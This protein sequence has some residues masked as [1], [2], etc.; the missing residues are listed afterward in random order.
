[1][2]GIGFQ[3]TG[4]HAIEFAAAPA[5]GFE[6]RI[7]N[8]ISPQP[9]QSVA[10]RC[11]IQI[12]AARRQYAPAERAGLR[13]LFGDPE[14]WG[15]TLKTLLWTHVSLNVPSFEEKASVELNVPCT[16]DFNVGA[17]KYFHAVQNA[18][19]PL[20]FQF[21]GTVF[22]TAQ[23]G[24][25][26]IGQIGWDQEARYNLPVEVWRDMMDHYYPNSAWLRL[27]R[28]SFE[29]LAGFKRQQGMA[30]WEE[31]IDALIHAEKEITL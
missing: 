23:D 14:R 30:T 26:K 29:R 15:Q 11:Q 31:A 16:F 17:T 22:Y 6:L 1:V 5:I 3:I 10:L 8:P 27:G 19:I 9:V 24:T 4:A 20:C 28:D 2:S 7:A 12:E 25:L 18:P 21:S 13:D